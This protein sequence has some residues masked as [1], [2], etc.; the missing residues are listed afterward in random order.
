MEVGDK[1]KLISNVKKWNKWGFDESTI[2]QIGNVLIKI[3]SKQGHTMYV[4]KS[5]IKLI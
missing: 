1:V 5:E 2:I 4:K 3:Q